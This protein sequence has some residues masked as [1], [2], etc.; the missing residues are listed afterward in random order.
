MKNI[1]TAF[2]ILLL[3]CPMFNSKAVKP[4]EAEPI[5]EALF[6]CDCGAAIHW[7]YRPI[8]KI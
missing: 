5:K 7:K 3:I 4:K 8:V 1:L 2:T 6:W